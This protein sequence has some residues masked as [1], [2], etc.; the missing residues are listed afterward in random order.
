M[1]AETDI[2]RMLHLAAQ[3]DQSA[4]QRLFEAVYLE[5]YGIA[6]GLVAGEQPGGTVHATALVNATYLRL[7]GQG[8]Q[9]WENRRH[10]FGAAARAMQRILIEHG[11]R[12]TAHPRPSLVTLG[13]V[14][15]PVEE[16]R[17]DWEALSEALEVLRQRDARMHEVVMLRFFAGQTVELT[18][19]LMGIS[20]RLVKR[21]W[22]FARAWLYRQLKEE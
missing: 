6:A 4:A 8:H 17:V 14:E 13:D 11:R 21:E 12:R 3:G 18:A 9:E 5:L 22:H 16:T 2:T 1:D 20:P 7:C 15:S 10:F 19:E